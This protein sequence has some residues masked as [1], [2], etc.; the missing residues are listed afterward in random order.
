M[1][2][3][4]VIFA[5]FVLNISAFVLN[6]L[7]V[8]PG[9]SLYLTPDM[10][11]SEFSLTAFASIGVGGAIAG[12][13][14]L[15]TRQYVYAVGAILIWIIGLVLPILQWVV[16]GLPFMLAAMLNPYGL[17]WFAAVIEGFFAI[18]IFIFCIEILSGKQI[19]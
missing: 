8:I 13:L 18:I 6:Y 9:P 17:G 14:A 19:T 3:Y 15:I 12:L 10:L 4:T 11:L 7:Q 5:Y 16:A 2:A 1:K